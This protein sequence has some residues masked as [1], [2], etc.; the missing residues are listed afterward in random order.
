MVHVGRNHGAKEYTYKGWEIFRDSLLRWCIYNQKSQYSRESDHIV[1][2]GT[3]K[4]AKERVN[5]EIE[6]RKYP[7]WKD[8]I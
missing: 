7:T 4:D 5:A 2:N 8:Q 6:M 1:V 3:L